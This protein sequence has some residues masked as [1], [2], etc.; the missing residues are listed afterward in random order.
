MVA[1]GS[2]EQAGLGAGAWA[3]SGAARSAA[4]RTGM[5][6]RGGMWLVYSGQGWRGMLGERVSDEV[7]VWQDLA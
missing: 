3:S 2:V 5:G 4:R 1:F 7:S 6:V